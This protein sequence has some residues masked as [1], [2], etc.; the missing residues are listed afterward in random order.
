M[1]GLL[2]A[3]AA[4]LSPLAGGLEAGGRAALAGTRGGNPGTVLYDSFS[5]QVPVKGFVRYGCGTEMVKAPLR[6]CTAIVP[7]TLGL[8]VRHRNHAL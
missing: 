4:C 8:A 3:T 2:Y 6:P 1:P 7:R 5:A